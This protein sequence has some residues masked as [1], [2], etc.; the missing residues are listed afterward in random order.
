MQVDGVQAGPER[1]AGSHQPA[2]QFHLVAA[3]EQPQIRDTDGVQ[4]GGPKQRAVEQRR[5]PGQQVL[6][7]LGA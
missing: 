7:R 6:A 2:V 3:D 5:D 4:G 1:Q